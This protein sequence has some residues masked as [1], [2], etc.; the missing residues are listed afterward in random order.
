MNY[1]KVQFASGW[2][3]KMKTY[4]YNLKVHNIPQ[5]MSRSGNCLDNSP[6]ENSLPS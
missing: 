3:Y 4:Q 2:G 1:V 5:S 6:I